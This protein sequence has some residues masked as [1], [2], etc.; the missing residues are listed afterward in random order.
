[1]V[2]ELGDIIQCV[3]RPSRT[4]YSVRLYVQYTATYV[5]SIISI[6][7]DRLFVQKVLTNV[8]NK[9]NK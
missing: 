5:V 6:M 1:M 3:L 8:K 4:V 2:P 7:Q 9:V